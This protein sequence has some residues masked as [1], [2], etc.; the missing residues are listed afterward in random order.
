MHGIGAFVVFPLAAGS[1]DDATSGAQR[2]R[3][4]QGAT[5]GAAVYGMLVGVTG[6]AGRCEERVRRWDQ[7]VKITMTFFLALSAVA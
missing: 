5:S 2:E 1:Q 4:E 3:G 6:P 7:A